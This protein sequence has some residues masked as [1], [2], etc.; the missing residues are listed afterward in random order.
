LRKVYIVE[1]DENIRELCVYALKSSGFEAVGFENASDFFAELKTGSPDLAVLDI[2]LPEEDG[3]SILKRLRGSALHNRLP[4]IMLTA[5]GSEYD[6]VKALDMGADDYVTKPFGVTELISRINAVLRRSAYASVNADKGV[7]TYK[8]I[9]FD[10]ER[11]V[12]MVD[13]DAVNF[14]YKEYELLR[15]L[16]INDGIVLSRDRLMEAVWG[17]DFEGE[18]RTVD[19]HI[20]TLRQKLGAAGAHIKTVRNVGYKLGE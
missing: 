18:S 2:M 6:K 17:F 12:V 16:L 7:L 15:Y 14:T 19:M 11:H 9:V 20:K 10:D 8:N 3:L 13:G 1:D 4:I 5:K